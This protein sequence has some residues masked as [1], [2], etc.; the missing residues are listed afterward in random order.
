MAAAED[1]Q[2]LRERFLA[3]AAAIEGVEGAGAEGKDPGV[4]PPAYF[5]SKPWLG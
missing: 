2:E 3:V 4:A 5:V 1:S